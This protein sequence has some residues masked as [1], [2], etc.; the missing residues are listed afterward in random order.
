[1]TID[2]LLA[3]R[4]TAEDRHFALEDMVVSLAA[5]LTR[6]DPSSGVDLKAA[7]LRRIDECSALPILGESRATRNLLSSFRADIAIMQ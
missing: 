7:L 3:H 6:R 4:A 2:P 1:M 5:L